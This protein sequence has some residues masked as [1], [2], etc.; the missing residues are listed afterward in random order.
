MGNE[1]R[2]GGL[3]RE[4][5]GR[6]DPPESL[7]Q[8]LPRSGMGR[9]IVGLGQDRR[10]GEHAI[11]AREGGECRKQGVEFR[12]GL[13]SCVAASASNEPA[14]RRV[15]RAFADPQEES[16]KEFTRGMQIAAAQ[17]IAL[18]LTFGTGLLRNK[19]LF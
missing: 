14:R 13:E 6:E 12:V 9:K 1:G 7:G 19:I 5:E 11:L 3:R 8:D 16:R 15:G 4:A 2:A 17:S 10:R 18:P